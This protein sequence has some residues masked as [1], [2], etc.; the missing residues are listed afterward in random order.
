M[1][2][3]NITNFRNYDMAETA[4]PEDAPKKGMD[5]WP[6]VFVVIVIVVFF[7]WDLT[8]P[9]QGKSAPPIAD[10]LA[11]F[12]AQYFGWMVLAGIAI[13]LVRRGLMA[14]A[15]KAAAEEVAS[16]C[17]NAVPHYDSPALP[18]VAGFL[19]GSSIAFAI[20]GDKFYYTVL[21]MHFQ[22]SIF[23]CVL[24][25]GFVASF[26]ILFVFA[27]RL[28]IQL[29]LIAK[30]MRKRDVGSCE[31]QIR[32]YEAMIGVRGLAY[33]SLQCAKGSLL[34]RQN[35]PFEALREYEKGLRKSGVG[36]VRFSLLY[37]CT[38]CYLLL[39][40]MA[41]ADRYLEA[42][43]TAV[44]KL[45]AEFHLLQTFS[46]IRHSLYADAIRLMDANWFEIEA[47]NPLLNLKTTRLERAFALEKINA[48]QHADEI[49]D[50]LGGARPFV[51]GEFD[52]LGW[53]WPEMNEFLRRHGFTASEQ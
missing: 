18:H 40:K 15:E 20:L 14:A 27:Y 35:R 21:G 34:I 47:E 31:A 42:T 53:H 28:Q 50:L 2:L 22:Q 51:P 16:P 9:E 29:N 41:A 23:W 43:R 6:L 13:W 52:Y 10:R 39:G 25:A 30:F 3:S 46:L 48:N 49:R 26:I 45:P 7:W 11:K 4:K 37:N 17:E 19:M 5:R 32:K 12:S 36:N 44:P 33:G 24:A 1:A 38:L 8:S